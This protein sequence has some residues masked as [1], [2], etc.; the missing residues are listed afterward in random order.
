MFIEDIISAYRR[1]IDGDQDALEEL[2]LDTI[3]YRRPP[4]FN[5]H[6]MSLQSAYNHALHLAIAARELDMATLQMQTQMMLMVLLA[7]AEQRNIEIQHC[8]GGSDVAELMLSLIDEK[9]A[10]LRSIQNNPNTEDSTDADQQDDST[11]SMLVPSVVHAS[12]PTPPTSI[13]SCT[14]P[15]PS[16]AT[17]S[18]QQRSL[19]APSPSA[20]QPSPSTPT[21]S[22]V[23]PRS[24]APSIS[25]TPSLTTC[26]PPYAKATSKNKRRHCSLCPFF[27][28]HL[29]LHFRQQHS[30]CF[31]TNTEKMK[32]VHAK[33]KLRCSK[34]VWRF[35]C[36]YKS[37]GAIITRLGQHLSRTHH[38]T[39]A[40]LLAQVKAACIRIPNSSSP[41]PAA[42]K[43]QP[44]HA[45]TPTPRPAT[46]KST[47]SNAESTS[48]ESKDKSFVSGGST[49]DEH[50]EVD[51]HQ[52]QV[53]GDLDNISTYAD[54]DAEEEDYHDSANNTWHNVYSSNSTSQNV[55]EY[56]MSRFY[57]YLVHV[58]GGAHSRQQ[59]LIHTCQV[60][61]ILNTLDPAGTVLAC[62]A[63]RR[64]LDVCD[65]F[66]VPKLSQQ[67]L[68]RNTI[69]TYLRSLEY[70][71]KFLAK[72]LLYNDEHLDQHQRTSMLSLRDRL[73]DYRATIHRRTAHQITTRIQPEDLRQVEASEPAQL[74]VKLLGLAQE[75]KSLTQTEFWAVR[76]YLPVTTLYENAS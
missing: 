41:S 45:P 50:V 67:Q 37:C 58:E 28:T 5:T 30:G 48:S 27:G 43:R 32:L 12:H 36:T 60:H 10:R 40:K 38:I 34:T 22:T 25:T 56:F 8:V 73:P 23:P 17:T 49:T 66:C 42:L 7:A 14:T 44:K 70:F 47:S 21:T 20:E 57:R 72:G 24:T 55:R 2:G 35:Q 51:H 19:A 61:N 9:T 1:V 59:A 75:G 16:A 26:K 3:D 64:G 31:N 69:K 74:A 52:L 63:R 4:P 15:L 29:Q 46:P 68:T 62:L 39:N 33:D 13:P 18:L 65:K 54:T 6:L 11:S 76:D 71:L 53:E